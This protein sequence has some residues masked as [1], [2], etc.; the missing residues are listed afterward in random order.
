MFAL[1][2]GEKIFMLKKISINFA[3]VCA[4]SMFFI[5]TSIFYTMYHYSDTK[6]LVI[7][8]IDNSL[9]EGAYATNLI[10]TEAY[11]DRVKDKNS[12]SEEEYLKIVN[13]LSDFATKSNLLYVYTMVSNGKEIYF[14]SSNAT[15]EE[16]KNKSY[17]KYFDLYKEPSEGLKK[18]FK[19]KEIVF[20]EYTDEFATVRSVFIPM[21]TSKG[22][23]YVIGADISLSFLKQ[24][25]NSLLY[26]SI[27]IGVVIL[28]FGIL[29]SIFLA[30]AIT[31]PLTVITKQ[32]D[33]LSLGENIEQEINTESFKEITNLAGSLNRLRIS[34]SVAMKQLKEK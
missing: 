19:T 28:I 12:I 30:I 17:S 16:F 5:L 33:G 26:N 14:T 11:H 22:A 6:R 20:D 29:M 27:L 7:N 8:G 10:L 25:L 34:L 9:K 32:A 4:T 3:L 15:E 31:K 23:E 21:K 1:C 13:V 24:K 18:A 2:K